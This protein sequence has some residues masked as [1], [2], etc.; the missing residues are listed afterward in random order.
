MTPGQ[1]DEWR[2]ADPLPIVPL[3]VENDAFRAAP[4][5]KLTSCTQFVTETF[6]EDHKIDGK[7]SNLI[8]LLQKSG[9]TAWPDGKH[10][11]CIC[12]G[13]QEWLG[14]TPRLV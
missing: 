2:S 12:K 4:E 1:C 10:G 5:T 13:A 8:G 9:L 3:L 14:Q 7:Y 11:M 6:H